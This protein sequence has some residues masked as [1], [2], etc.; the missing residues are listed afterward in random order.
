MS[1]TTTTIMTRG[2]EH[3]SSAEARPKLVTPA[4]VAVGAI[5]FGAMVSFYLLAAAAPVFAADHIGGN[6]AA[7]ASTAALMAGTVV[8]ELSMRRLAHRFGSR[9]LIRAAVV[10]LG[11]P[12][13]L[14]AVTPPSLAAF[15]VECAARGIG[16]GMLVVTTGVIVAETLP[17]ERRGEGFGLYGI[18]VGLPSIVALPFGV[19]LAHAVG[20]RVVFM[21][22][23]VAAFSGAGLTSRISNAVGDDGDHPRLLQTIRCGR[24]GGPACAFAATTVAV[25]VVVTFLPMAFAGSALTVTTALL[26]QAISSTAARW[27]AGR[28]GDRRGHDRLL[29]P[30]LIVAA[31]GVV[32]L[33]LDGGR[34]V[35]VM[36]MTA[37]GAGFGIVI[38][39]SLATMLER[40][41]AS[42]HAAVSAL[43][44]LTY[45]AGWGIGALAF[46]IVASRTGYALGF[47]ITGLAMFIPLLGGTRRRTGDPASAGLAVA[48]PASTAL[49]A[50][51]S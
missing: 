49:Y 35:A 33:A 17:A 26:A 36:A 18:I 13:A 4:F 44:N 32:A 39:A 19:W 11:A 34:I 7:G 37:F 25:G 23:A 45:D 3:E 10:L 47:A 2:S 46:G 43:W 9:H 51:C 24:L 5:T 50:A 30:G 40:V 20:D 28:I 16:F 29:A 12:A 31:I 27:V 42:H 22:A 48:P 8:A 41:T 21:L 38:S 14:T 6:F 1:T 15:L